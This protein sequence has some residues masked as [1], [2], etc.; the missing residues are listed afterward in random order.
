MILDVA[1]ENETLISDDDL[2]RAEG[3]RDVLRD[4]ILPNV[5]VAID[6]DYFSLS[7]SHDNPPLSIY[8]LL[9][10]LTPTLYPEAVRLSD[11]F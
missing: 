3:R 10:A 1:D 7:A 5:I 4:G 9:A 2:N 11:F 8:W 6:R